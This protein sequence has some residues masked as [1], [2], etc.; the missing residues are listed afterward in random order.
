MNRF[1]S[2]STPVWIIRALVV[3][4][5]GAAGVWVKH[6][7]DLSYE[8]SALKDKVSA[9]TYMFKHERER[10]VAAERFARTAQLN[11]EAAQAE[12]AERAKDAAAG[13]KRLV[14]K[15]SVCDYSPD[16]VRMLNRARGYDFRVPS[17]SYIP[18]GHSPQVASFEGADEP[19]SGR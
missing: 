16:V 14:P 6:R 18:S 15:S 17:N 2:A 7:I 9:Y 12:I 1:F 11:L 5:V 8:A 3:V 4:A 19:A 10:R 13:A